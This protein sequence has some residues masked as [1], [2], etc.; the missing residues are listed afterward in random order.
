MH[1]G[2]ET[3]GSLRDQ[4]LKVGLVDEKQ[5]KKA[6]I[7]Q[8]RQ[9][10]K[11]PKN[12]IDKGKRDKAPLESALAEK[13]ARDRELNRQR[14]RQAER[15]AVAAQIRQLIDTHRI[16]KDEGDVPFNFEHDRKIKRIYISESTRNQLSRG[17]L[18]I[19]KFDGHYELV[20][21]TIAEKICLRDEKCLILRNKPQQRNAD[22]SEAPYTDYRV[23]DDLI[24]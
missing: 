15:K 18:A 14:Q 19:V 11:R 17:K 9:N 3:M 20:P 24:W 6:K 10:K 2:D 8:R 7:D 16:P 1:L 22:E 5:V 4:L 23:P 12:K 13:I 21:T